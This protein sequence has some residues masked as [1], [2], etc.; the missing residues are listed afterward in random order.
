MLVL[1]KE[2]ESDII[3]SREGA[4][5][6]MAVYSE[7]IK[8]FEKI[9][10]Y[11]R[12]F[13]IFG[14]RTRENF[15]GKSKRTYDNEK[16]RIES[17]LSE[18]IHTELIGHRKKVSVNI[19]SSHIYQNPLYQ[20]YRSKSYTDNDIR[21][22]FILMDLLDH[23]LM[24]VS[25]IT[26][27]MAA[28]YGMVFDTQIV[29]LK[30]K[31]YVEEGLIQ[32]KRKGNTI[33]FTKSNI[34]ADSLVKQYPA[35]KDMISFF[36]EE[37]PFGIAGN[38]L[39]HKA[40]FVNNIFTRKHAYMVHTLDDE[41]LLSV[42]DA[43]QQKNEVILSCIGIKH[44]NAYTITAVPLK[45][46]SSL[47]TGRNYIIMYSIQQKRL[48]SVRLDSVKKVMKSKSCAD[49]D[50]YYQYYLNN[51]KYLWGTSFGVV[52]KYGQTEHIHMEIVI[53]EAK[54]QF[55]VNRLI[56]EGRNGTVTKISGGRYAYDTNLFDANEAS[57]WIKT[58]IGRIAVFESTNRELQDKFRQ[59]IQRMQEMYGGKNYEAFF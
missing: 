45:I 54:E 40:D 51:L 57:P 5:T 10:D 36:S 46:H 17:W 20:C 30:L 26:D 48:L 16:R 12:E 28:E 38:F 19:D 11:V 55:V 31:E 52:R 42:F 59:D 2:L 34:Y 3:R 18:Y 53:D 24:T 50:T 23:E 41:I 58:F 14:F 32:S 37:I 43:M 39:M 29:R 27:R 7:L 49:Y 33:C 25:E 15:D 1:I 47:Q 21:L 13:Y 44:R 6:Y 9:R 22:H 4:E 35:I 8:N 56:R